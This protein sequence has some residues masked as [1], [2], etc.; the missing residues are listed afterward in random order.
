MCKMDELSENPQNFLSDDPTGFS[1]DVPR[2]E[3]S[4]VHADDTKTMV[5]VASQHV[6]V[7]IN[8]KGKTITIRGGSDA[9]TI[10]YDTSTFTNR[11]SFGS[12]PSY[13]A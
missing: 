6:Q 4:I 13:I 2:I 9:T 8:K 1:S 11:W 10:D 12:D 7:Q 3:V 5:G